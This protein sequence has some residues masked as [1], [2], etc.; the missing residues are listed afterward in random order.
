MFVSLCLS[1]LYAL[2]NSSVLMILCFCVGCVYLCV[3]SDPLCV[4]E[5]ICV[6]ERRSLSG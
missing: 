6:G 1:V 3:V 2:G 4:V 5:G